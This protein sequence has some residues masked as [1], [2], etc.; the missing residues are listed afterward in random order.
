MICFNLDRSQLPLSELGAVSRISIWIECMQG[1]SEW[2]TC[3][4]MLHSSMWPY[5]APDLFV[6][7]MGKVC[8]GCDEI[9]DCVVVTE[10]GVL[11]VLLH[12]EF[13]RYPGGFELIF[14]S[15]EKFHHMAVNMKEDSL[16]NTVT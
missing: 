15:R 14:Q 10:F 13:S 4:A 6:E 16:L 7:H 3:I 9:T 5:S 1:G 11:I 8:E 12:V 2:R